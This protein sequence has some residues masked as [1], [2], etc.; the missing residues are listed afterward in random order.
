MTVAVI[1]AGRMGGGMVRRLREWGFDTV[2]F[3]RAR[4][5][6]EALTPTGARVATTARE[7]VET[8]EFVL[9]SVSNDEAVRSAYEGP[10]GVIAALHSGEVV[11]E[12]STI[13]PETV[14][15]LR[16][17]VEEK[18]ATL[19]DTPVSGSVQL[20]ERGEL[21]V[22]V[23]GGTEALERARPVLDAIAT[24][25]FHVGPSGTGAT[26]KLVVNSVLSGLNQALSESLVL[27]ELAG[28]DRHAAY[29]VLSG[30]AVAAPYLHYKRP[31][32]ENPE[33]APV[34]FSLHLVAKDLDLIAALAD[35]VGARVD[36]ISADRAVVREALQA[37][38]GDRDLS[39][40]AVF[41][42]EAAH[43]DREAQ[44]SHL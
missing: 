27:A 25:V 36:Q 17:L 11:L 37:G 42:R 44:P 18:G 8:A 1:G 33:D 39:A 43:R 14:A 34:A 30:T 38:F 23:G 29:D 16:P 15:E 12:A 40:L 19:L 32:F 7:A 5:K 31:A 28:V 35:R 10:D 3:N 6:A 22:M 21:T 20:L 4:E 41:L 26:M 13:A 24:K 9:V 2:V